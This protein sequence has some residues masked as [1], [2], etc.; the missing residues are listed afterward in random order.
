MA[1]VDDKTMAEIK[2]LLD[3]YR[4]VLRASRLSLDTQ[5]S[6]RVHAEYF[7]RWLDNDFEPGAMA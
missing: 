5:N 4:G 7:V 6:Y 2:R 3:E 1:K